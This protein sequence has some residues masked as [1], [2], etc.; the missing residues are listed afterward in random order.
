[1]V[2]AFI[3]TSTYDRMVHKCKCILKH[4]DGN[5]ANCKLKNL[6][7]VPKGSC[8]KP[9]LTYHEVDKICELLIK[10]KFD[11]S[12]V[13]A[14]LHYLHNIHGIS[15]KSMEK[16]VHRNVPAYEDVINKWFDRYGS[17]RQEVEENETKK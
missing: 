9:K 17:N 13:F 14:D 16:I 12:K 2:R 6:E 1:M 15:T 5:R 7:F 11:R 10:H 8:E 4:I 3:G